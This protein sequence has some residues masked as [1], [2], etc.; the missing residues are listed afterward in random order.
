MTS[1]S[2]LSAEDRRIRAQQAKSAIDSAGWAFDEVA[3]RNFDEWL[4][5]GPEQTEQRERLWRMARQTMSV[6]A[7]LV[8]TIDNYTDEGVLREHRARTKP[9]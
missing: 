7:T 5:T 4:N 2:E 1:I 3:R 6:K 8:A 9:E